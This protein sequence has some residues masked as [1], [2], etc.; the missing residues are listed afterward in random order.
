M[1]R[2]VAVLL[3]M[4]MLLAGC[5]APKPAAKES[6]D[7][8]ATYSG[9]LTTIN[10]LVTATTAEAG[11]AAN[12]VDGLVEYDNLG[13]LKPA[14]AKSW[15]V[16]PDGLTWTFKIRPG[17][18]WLTWEGK[19]YAEV[20]AQDWVD[21]LRYIFDA[22]N[23]S[24]VANFAFLAVKNGEEFFKGTV[25]DFKEV[26]VKALDK[27][28]LQYT[29]KAPTPYFLTMLTWVS[30]YPVNGKYLAEAG[31][32]FGTTHKTILYNGAYI[33]TNW[34]NSVER[35]M[36]KNEKYWD[37]GNVNIKKMSYKFNKEASTLAPEMF[38]RGEITGAAIPSALI[39]DWMAD[40]AKK[41]MVC[42]APT[43]W[44]SYF[45]AFNFNPKFDDEYQPENWRVV[46]N[47]VN[48]RRSMFYALDRRAAMLTSEPYNPDRRISNSLTPKTFCNVNG[49]DFVEVGPMAEITKRDSFNKTEALKYK[50]LAK[51]ELAGK[52][53]FP[54]KVPMPYNSS[55][56]DWTN[57]V[58][59]VEQQV[60]GLLGADYVDIIPVSYPPTNF[61]TES[62]RAG[63]YA[64]QECNGGPGFVDPDAYTGI[65]MQGNTLLWS[66]FE[67]A[68]EYLDAD[69]KHEYAK[70][71]EKARAEVKDTQKRYQLFAEAE[72]W[73]INQAVLIPYAIGGG[74]YVATK[75]EP[76]SQPWSLSLNGVLFKY[77]RVLD[78]AVSTEQYNQIYQKWQTDRA[79]A[80]K[81]AAGTK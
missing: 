37:A 6:G 64:I 21:A 75:L 78:K 53:T 55:S 3:L 81:A 60:E 72:A 48:F 8:Y 74:G 46:V 71:I 40:P 59:V 28:T 24:R 33:I 42:P 47:N 32:K 49:I 25:K 44:Y 34:E 31:D 35:I 22:K 5:S 26:G 38:L 13:V 62:R 17:V 58:Q 73:L 70:M 69:G 20:V 10:Y 45:Y 7:Y 51:K 67:M 11:V 27:Y 80:L 36:V 23:A 30:F 76:L 43:S 2:L 15:E 16:S 66:S 4:T 50:D 18:K 54:V 1:K 57:R 56:T 39:T 61:L 9:E 63:R 29:L 19:E 79:A 41:N 68:T 65:F 12:C 77:A 14:L 52:A